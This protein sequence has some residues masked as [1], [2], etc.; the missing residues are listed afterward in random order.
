M[1]AYVCFDDTDVLG[2]E[3]G[4]GKLAKM[5]EKRLP[6]GCSLWSIVRQ[7]FPVEDGIPFTSH[8]SSACVVVEVPGPEVRQ[9]LI[10]AACSHVEELMY[11]GSDPG[12]CVA[13]DGD[14]GFEDLLAFGREAQVRIVTQAEA[15]AAARHVHLSGHGGTNDGIIGAAAGVGLTHWGWTGRF[16]EYA[17]ARLRTF[18]ERTTP[19]EVERTG[20]ML[21]TLD[22]NVVQPR[23]DDA[24][25]FDGWMRPLMIGGRPCL[26]LTKVSEGRWH[27][28]S[29]KSALKEGVVE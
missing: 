27:A 20:I 23:P 6:E 1:R 9:S 24:I 26:P 17:P 4:T 2:A 22:R 3:R 19:A 10:G 5:F 16:L 21:V 14:D 15:I 11:D 8:N 28:L 13:F 12:V 18:V 25:E 7:Q 29:R